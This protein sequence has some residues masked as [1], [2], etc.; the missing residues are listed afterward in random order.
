MGVGPFFSYVS[1]VSVLSQNF[2]PDI[3]GRSGPRKWL[4]MPLAGPCLDFKVGG[5]GLDGR[6]L[7]TPW[8]W[9]SG[10]PHRY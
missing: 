8:R 2:C 3:S 6:V 10:D 4:A 5:R 7:K 9:H 1:A